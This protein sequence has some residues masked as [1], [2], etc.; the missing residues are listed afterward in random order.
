MNDKDMRALLAAMGEWVLRGA[1]QSPEIDIYRGVT[2]NVVSAGG[3]F[4]EAVSHVV[5]AMLQSPRFLYRIEQSS[6]R[7]YLAPVS[8]DELASRMS[9]II[10][11][12]SPDRELRQKA[13]TGE[14]L[15]RE[16]ARV[17][18]AV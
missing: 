14:V 10:W 1:L 8:G 15:R 9:Y 3:G 12:S 6:G 7:D 5:E 13:R 16:D 4:D 18:R 17:A 11:G 2:T